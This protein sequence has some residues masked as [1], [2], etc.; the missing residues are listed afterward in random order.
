MKKLFSILLVCILLLSLAVKRK[1][2]PR[3]N[4][5]NPKHLLPALSP[6]ALGERSPSPRR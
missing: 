5:L 2:P 1:R 6:T 3:R 4:L